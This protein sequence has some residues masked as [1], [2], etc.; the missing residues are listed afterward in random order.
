MARLD[1]VRQRAWELFLRP[2]PPAR[3]A[4]RT[5]LSRLP[6]GEPAPVA[7]FSVFNSEHLRRAMG[8]AAELMRLAESEPDEQGL[9]AALDRYEALAGRENPDLLDYALM[10]FITHHRRGRALTHV[11]PPVTL[12]NP[13]LVAPSRVSPAETVPGLRTGGIASGGALPA[14]DGLEWYREDPFANE[15]HTHWHVVYPFAGVPDPADPGRPRFKDR[16][17]ELFLY[18]HEQMLARYDAERRALGM[19]RIAPRADYEAE[20]AVGYDPGPLLDEQGF[21]A[22]PP[23]VRM[24]DLRDQNGQ[25]VYTAQDHQKRRERIDEAIRQRSY[26]ELD[27][28]IPMTDVSLLGSTIEA[29]GAGVH[30]PNDALSAYGDLHNI[31]HGMIAGAS[32]GGEGVMRS[33]AVAIRDPVFWEWHKHIDD[34]Y[35]AWQHGAGARPLEPLPVRVRDSDVFLAFA[36][37]LPSGSEPELAAWA[38]ETFGG[39]HWDEAAPA[40]DVT[41]DVLETA[42]LGRSL[43][44][45]DRATVVP[46]QHLTHRPFAYV[47]RLENTGDEPLPVTVRIFLVPGQ[48]AEDRRSWIELDKFVHRLDQRERGVVVRFGAQSAVIRKPAQMEPEL[49][50]MAAFE[51]TAAEVDT[52]AAAGLPAATA[53]LL[54]PFAGRVASLAEV[55][56]A[57]GPDHWE[58]AVP[59]LVRHGTILPSE[60]PTRPDEDDTPEEIEQLEAENYCTCGWPYNLLLPRGTTDGMPFRLAVICTD[61]RDDGAGGEESCGSL[62]F[63]GARDRYPDRRPMGYPF[64]RE[65]PAPIGQT[66]ADAGHAAVRD[67]TIRRQPDTVGNG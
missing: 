16:Q 38:Q 30:G 11:I 13:E 17:G 15:H 51:L 23:G 7:E 20:M 29:D 9:A 41:T 54:R 63:C 21:P 3:A 8:V 64:D 48:D 45:A 62:S 2:S 52:M 31:G 26:T 33:P 67:L 46:L 60:Q 56:E 39:E 65:F 6:A 36:D 53:A 14:P 1:G 58:I 55:F 42:M 22:R 27:P 50:K 37:R 59:F 61:A 34:F 44:L 43:T 57:L 32:T 19:A 49:L 5:E 18:M 12:R 35:A 47:L 25:V 40:P 24:V 28:P 4:F 10:V 66:L